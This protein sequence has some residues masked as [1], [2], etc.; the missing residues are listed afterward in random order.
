VLFLKLKKKWPNLT[1]DELN[2]RANKIGLSAL[3]YF[4]LNFN[5]ETTMIYD[6]KASLKFNGKT[7]PYALYCYARCQSIF[8]KAQIN[9]SEITFDPKVLH[10]LGST[11][12]EYSLLI[13]LFW[14]NCEVIRASNAYDTSKITEA[15]FQIVKQYS[16]FYK[17]KVKHPIVNCPDPDLKKARLMLIKSV[18]IAIKLGLNLLGIETLEQM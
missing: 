5:P 1:V 9:S 2:Y 3:K 12:E 11:K 17:D 6:K 13:S 10:L 4:L 15:I 8:R 7:G 16:T 14:F 18:G